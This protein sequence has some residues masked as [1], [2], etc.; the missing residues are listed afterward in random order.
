MGILTLIA[1]SGYYSDQTTYTTSTVDNTVTAGT[2]LVF[3]VFTLLLAIGSYALFSYF[4]GRIFKKAGLP[5]WIAWVPIYN[6]WKMLEI[7]GQQ[8]FWSVL[9][10]I[11]FVN[12]AAA[13]FMYIAMYNI[14][15]K[16]DKSGSF[17]LLAIFLSPVWTIWLALDESRWDDSKGAPSLA[18][19][20]PPATNTTVS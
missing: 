4:L 20:V 13:V 3:F 17:I 9:A 6:S 19:V 2:M 16:L 7:G 12:I 18:Y 1:Q 5:Q 14:G 11:P 10:I 15:L 8:G